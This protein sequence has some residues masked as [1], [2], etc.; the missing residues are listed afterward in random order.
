MKIIY[1]RSIVL[2][3]QLMADRSPRMKVEAPRSPGIHVQAINKALGVA[4]GKLDGDEDS[5]FER[6]SETTYPLMMALGVGWEEFRASHYSESELLWQP[7][8]LERDGLFGTPDGLLLQ[9]DPVSIWECK[10]TTKKIQ[11]ISSC[12]MYLKQSL[13]YCAMAGLDR[14]QIDILWVCGD[15]KRPY[16]PMATS[17]LVEFT[18]SE[19]ES[20]WKVLLKAAKNVKSE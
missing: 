18:E 17:S 16:Q 13:S 11:S 14:V 8:E 2:T 5:P 15:Y 9:H 7:G 20:W 12:W 19:I 1:E 10:R 4:A 6:M 3:P